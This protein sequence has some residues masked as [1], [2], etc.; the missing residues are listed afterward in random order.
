[1]FDSVNL[2]LMLLSFLLSAVALVLSCI[3]ISIVTGF[4]NSTHTIEWK[5]LETPTP[6]DD[7]FSTPDLPIENP[8]KRQPK[9]KNP[10]PVEELPKEED[11]LDLDD[12]YV[13]SNNF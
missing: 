2:A 1:M 4:K 5:P 12:P 3:T 9:I 11:F 6:E 7:P 8:N 13:T 10:H